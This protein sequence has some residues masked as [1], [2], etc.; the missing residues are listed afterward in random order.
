MGC[1]PAVTRIIVLVI[2]S[3]VSAAAGLGSPASSRFT[4]RTKAN[5]RRADIVEVF[6]GILTS[7]TYFQLFHAEEH[8]FKKGH[9]RGQA[10]EAVPFLRVGVLQTEAPQR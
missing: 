1:K 8:G 7:A 2:C 4:A 10:G 6:I 9:Q 3:V 5:R